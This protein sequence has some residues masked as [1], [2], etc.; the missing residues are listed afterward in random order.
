[1]KA[2]NIYKFIALCLTSAA[3]QSA[4]GCRLGWVQFQDSCYGFARQAMTWPDA[5]TLC[6]AYGSY[7]VEINSKS[8]NDWIV[9]QVKSRTWTQVWLGSSDI[10]NESTF[11]WTSSGETMGAFT[12]YYA[13]Q[14]D[15]RDDVEHCLHIAQSLGYKWN[16]EKCLDLKRFVCEAKMQVCRYT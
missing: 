5:Q 7:L 1:M 8:E 14:P 13:E 11:Q 16:D 9:S 2:A 10:F 3:V 6:R 12:D 15:N 4:T